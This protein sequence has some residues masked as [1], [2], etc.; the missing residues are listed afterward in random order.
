MADAI[1]SIVL[2][3]LASIA[4]QQIQQEV[5]LR[6]ENALKLK[7]KVCS[8]FLSP[9]FCFR[10]VILHHDIALKIKEINES[11]DDIAKEKDRYNFN[12]VE[13][14]EQPQRVET[15]SLIDESKI[16]GRDKEND[17]LGID[18]SM[19]ERLGLEGTSVVVSSRKQKNV[20]EAVEKLKAK[21]I[22]VIGIENVD[23]AVEKLKAKETENKRQSC[24]RY[25]S[26]NLNVRAQNVALQISSLNRNWLGFIIDF[27]SKATLIGFMAGVAI[28]V[29]LQQLKALL[30][31]T[32]LSF[33]QTNWLFV[34]QS[35]YFWPIFV[36]AGG[37]VYDPE[38]NTWVEMPVG[39]GGGWLVREA[40][41]KLSVTVEGEL[42]ALDPSTAHDSAKSKDTWKI[43]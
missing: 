21:G 2:E 27:L 11:L 39:M 19:A 15:T 12:M 25:A 36:D 31:I 4:R 7:K 8:F 9:C 34:P 18:F 41:T 22:K 33:H 14:V 30:G 35:L 38:V 26:M 23:E 29:S 20:D 10:Q 17:S 28:I 43:A 5:T 24:N 1:V 42:Y 32:H 6:A 40:G 16:F 3:Q 37:K 13:S